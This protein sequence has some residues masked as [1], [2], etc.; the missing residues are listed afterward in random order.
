M[1]NVL[2]QTAICYKIQMYSYFL[3][4]S[5]T[6][7]LADIGPTPKRATSVPKELANIAPQSG[8]PTPARES[9]ISRIARPASK[10]SL[11]SP[12]PS[13]RETPSPDPRPTPKA[14]KA[15]SKRQSMAKVRKSV[16]NK[17]YGYPS[18]FS[19]IYAQSGTT[20][21][22]SCLLPWSKG[23]STLLSKFFPLRADIVKG[24]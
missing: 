18:M 11:S 23:R 1:H 24:G 6:E 8:L 21:V 5:G 14:E 12:S 13:P 15:E 3:I 20:L 22:T 17:V 9:G 16:K 7:N 19:A 4:F 10:E 2:N